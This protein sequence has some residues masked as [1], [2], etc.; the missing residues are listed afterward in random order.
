[1]AKHGTKVKFVNFREAA[2]KLQ[3]YADTTPWSPPP[4][5]IDGT[6]SL[7][8]YAFPE[9]PGD[10]AGTRLVDIDNDSDLDFLYSN[11]EACG[12]L[13]FEGPDKGW[14]KTVYAS[15]RADAVD[16]GIWPIPPFVSEG[17][18]QGAWFH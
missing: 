11:D 6:G 16:N 2:E 1:M 17:Q 5:D 7:A 9:I 8:A 18:E 3:G 14:S 10:P 12:L 13:L 15:L 4:Q